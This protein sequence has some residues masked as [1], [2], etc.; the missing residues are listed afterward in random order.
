MTD[1]QALWTVIGSLAALTG[2]AFLFLY[3]HAERGMG[4]LWKKLGELGRASSGHE[5]QVA[6][7]YATKADLRDLG[8]ELRS[9]MQQSEQRVVNAIRDRAPVKGGDND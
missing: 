5:L 4:N 6:R 2:A 7:E 9:T 3:G 1:S 8:H